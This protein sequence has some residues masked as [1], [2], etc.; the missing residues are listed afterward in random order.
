MWTMT[1]VLDTPSPEVND[2]WCGPPRSSGPILD[3]TIYP[4]SASLPDI[5]QALRQGVEVGEHQHG[6]PSAPPL[7]VLQEVPQEVPQAARKAEEVFQAPQE[8]VQVCTEACCINL[9]WFCLCSKVMICLCTEVC[10]ISISSFC[11]GVS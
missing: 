8:V 7:E 11:F 5:S 6:L 4:K 10:C 9:A 1:E 3:L 2:A